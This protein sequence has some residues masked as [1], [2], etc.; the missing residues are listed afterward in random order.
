M[1]VCVSVCVY[2]QMCVHVSESSII[3]NYLNVYTVCMCTC[4]H[5]YKQYIRTCMHTML[6]CSCPCDV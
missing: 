6:E 5:M 4:I 2:V 3:I 1:H